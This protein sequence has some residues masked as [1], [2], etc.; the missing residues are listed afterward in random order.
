M[1]S[2]MRRRRGFV[3]AALGGD[4]LGALL[5][6]GLIAA[7]HHQRATGGPSLPWVS[8]GMVAGDDRGGGSA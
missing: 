7:R 8:A 5:G 2:A 4:V 3:E 1:R 6:A